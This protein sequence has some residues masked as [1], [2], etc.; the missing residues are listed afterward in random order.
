MIELNLTTS[1]KE[2]E[3]IKQYLQE[4]ASEMLANKINNGVK[5]VKDNV[6]LINKKD[7]NSFMKYAYEEARK[8]AEKGSNCACIEDK[9]V[10]GWAI[11]YFEEDTIEGTLY[12]EDGT[13]YKPVTKKTETPKV[14]SKPIQKKPEKQQASL[15]DLFSTIDSNEPTKEEI[16]EPPIEYEVAEADNNIDEFSEKEIDEELDNVAKSIK[17]PKQEPQIKEFYRIYHEQELTY[18]DV[19]VLTR[20]GDFYEAYNE[21][22]KRIANILNLILTSR[23]VGLENKVTLAGFPIHIKDKY[24]EKIQKFYTVLIIEN[25]EIN[26]YEKLEEKCPLQNEIQTIDK[27]YMKMLYTILDGKITIK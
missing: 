7:L 3:I 6:N 1:N 8:L 9:V 18:P 27:D 12:N 2:Q 26:F 21:N 13:E 20:L 19:V 10:F 24:L 11:H 14:E 16:E 22:A 25:D 4:N 17:T 15:F 5:F 23:D